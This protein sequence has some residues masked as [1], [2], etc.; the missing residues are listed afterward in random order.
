MAQ[1]ETLMRRNFVDYASY[2][3]LDRAIPDLRDGLKPVQRRI[4]HTLFEMHDGRYH[5]VA[6][7]IGETMKLHPHGDASIGDALVVLASKGFFIDRQ[8]NFGNLL[9]GHPAAAPRY[10]ECRLTPLALENLFNEALTEFAPSYD[11]RNKEPLCLPSKLPVVLMQGI[12]GIAVGMA[13]KIL[14]HNLVE[15]WRAQIGLLRGE[16][17]EIQ[18]DF[19]QGGIADVSAYDDG[20]GKV[21]IRARIAKRGDKRVVIS[22]VAYGT[23]TESLIASIEA[24]VQKGRVKV[25]S[26]DDFTTDRVEIELVLPRGVTAAEVIPQLYAYT[27]CSVSV[28][29]NVVVIVD[30]RPVQMTVSEALQALTEQLRERI[31]AELEWERGQLVDRRHWL[32]LEQIFVE[33]R[34]YKR[35]EEATTE[36]AVRDEVLTGMAAFEELFVRP[37]VDEDVK[38]LLELR[39]RRISAYDIE[40]NRRDIDEVVARIAEVEEKLADLTRTTTVYLEGLIETYGKQFSRR[41]EI[42]SFEGIDKK[43]V[44]RQTIK[45]AYDP[46]TRLF[47]S[48]VR[49]S[50]FKMTASEYD[51]ILGISD[52]GSYR[53]MTPPEKLFFSGRLIH[54]A[55]FDPDR[56]FEFTLVYRDAGRMAYGK[57]VRIDRFIRNREYRLVKDEKGKV[58]LLLPDGEEGIVSMQFV[59][60]K[61]QRVRAARFDLS[62]LEPT[63]VNARGVRLASKPVARLKLLARKRRPA[64]PPSPVGGGQTSLF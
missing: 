2:A 62:K 26:I 15:L 7:V 22:E 43:A 31:R 11:G 41:T 3:I 35:I 39:I 40:R 64:P 44:A 25:A 20:R 42:A 48:A 56:G 17:I 34:V 37:L 13:T 23:T 21:E 55:L 19:P 52:D 18:P 9:T 38:R 16:S 58:D 6:N 24:A 47:G 28:S 27:D 36:E 46:K 4:L 53:V 59:P 33:Q 32:T 8:G 50:K 30:R 54:C 14:P 61:R 1:L 57:R 49:G 12:E 45:L 29:S 51:L 63:G 5:K 60:A 10:I